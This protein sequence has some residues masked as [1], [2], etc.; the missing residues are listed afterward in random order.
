M[1]TTSLDS[2]LAISLSKPCSRFGHG[3]ELA[4]S[5]RSWQNGRPED[6]TCLSVPCS[7]PCTAQGNTKLRRVCKTHIHFFRTEPY[8]KNRARINAAAAPRPTALQACLPEQSRVK[9]SNLLTFVWQLI[10]RL[11]PPKYTGPLPWPA[12][13]SSP[14]PAF[15]Q[16]LFLMAGFGCLE[17]LLVWQ[18]L[19]LVF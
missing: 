14:V 15:Q 9:D 5:T 8:I 1:F 18:G 13:M 2:R 4:P 12:C 6:Q 7:L 17:A 19:G 10:Q 3:S 16:S 11:T